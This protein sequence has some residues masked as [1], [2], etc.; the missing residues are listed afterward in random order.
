MGKI[1][2]RWF[3]RCPARSDLVEWAETPSAESW[4]LCG[5]VDADPEL[6]TWTR[7]SDLLPIPPLPC[8]LA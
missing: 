8:Q 7:S 1:S 4:L 3:K 5:H 2:P 6:Y